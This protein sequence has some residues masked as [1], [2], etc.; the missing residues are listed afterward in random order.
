MRSISARLVFVSVLAWTAM[1]CGSINNKIVVR[2]QG[3]ADVLDNAALLDRFADLALMD[4]VALLS[5]AVYDKPTVVKTTSKAEYCSSGDALAFDPIEMGWKEQ[6]DLPP[7]PTP[8][9]GVRRVSGLHYRV[10]VKESGGKKIAVLA[11]RG[12]QSRS[13]WFSNLRWVT[14]VVPRVWDHYEQLL[15][16]MPDLVAD[17]KARNGNDIWIIPAGHS[18]GG[19]L[20]QLAGYSSGGSVKRV[21]A[22]DPSTVTHYYGVPRTLREHSKEGQMV[23]RIFE[24][25]EVL[26][27]VRWIIK[28]VYP[29]SRE[30]PQIV[31][32]K[33]HRL[34]G[35]LFSDHSIRRFACTPQPTA[36]QV[37][38]VTSSPGSPR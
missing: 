16:I 6:L 14:M 4:E 9:A 20:A 30:N 32:V 19:G 18:L 7:L 25:G 24:Q 29:I 27:Y 38:G 26:S 37:A 2:D 1:S 8:P 12:T 23:F 13:D 33:F 36:T 5:A 35:G 15:R 11:F 21:M 28:R 34:G 31:Q 10:W 3:R 22:F 17:I